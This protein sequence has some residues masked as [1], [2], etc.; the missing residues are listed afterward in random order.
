M[1]VLSRRSTSLCVAL[2][3]VLG[4]SA[5]GG[6]RNVTPPGVAP[7]RFLFD[8]GTAELMMEHWLQAR[9][10]FQRIVDG[11]PQSPTRPDAKLGIGDSYLGED[12]AE[13]LVYAANEFREFQQFY[14]THARADYA[15]Y[16]LA[17]S[18]FQQM[19]APE[20]D[21][22][23]TRAAIAE[24]NTFFERYPQ[25]AL[26]PEVRGKWRE[27][28]DR[29]SAASYQVGVYYHR[30]KWYPGA[31]DRFK[32]ILRDDPGYSGRDGVYFYLADSLTKTDKKAEALPYLDRLVKEFDQSEYLVDARKQLA[33]LQAQ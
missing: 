7:D 26:T 16:R 20:R 17:M 32:E 5:C 6:P 25:S 18:H 22:S 1:T 8:R 11:Y 9:E 24:F 33:E 10:Y 28:K 30:V 12:T 23:E 31:I 13:S 19:K 21:Q 3:T 15:Q 14:P 27:A 4:I 2:V 29:L